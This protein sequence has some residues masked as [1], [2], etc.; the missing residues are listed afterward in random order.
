MEY[1]SRRVRKSTNKKILALLLHL[2]QGGIMI[3]G[4]GVCMYKGM[5][6]RLLNW[7][8]SHFS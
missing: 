7:F 4:I 5:G 2:L 6:V 8:F 3:S 1:Y